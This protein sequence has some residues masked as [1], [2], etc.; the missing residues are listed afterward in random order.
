MRGC[1]HSESADLHVDDPISPSPGVLT[2]R[3]GAA[4]S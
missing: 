2:L 1:D 4:L 3:G